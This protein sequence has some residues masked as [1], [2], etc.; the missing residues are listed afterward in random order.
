M[1]PLPR[2]CAMC[3]SESGFVLFTPTHECVLL[4]NDRNAWELPGGRIEVGESPERCLQREFQEELTVSIDVRDLLDTY[5]FEVVP[6]RHV[7]IVT[8]GCSLA[9]AFAP[10][11]S[12]EHCQVKT[13]PVEALPANF[14]AGYRRSIE[15]W[16]AR[17]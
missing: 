2:T 17:R 6:G 7:F 1:V 15:A 9:G 10:R 5:L 14:P 16:H 4:L 13:F 11:I 8:F 3:V 12:E